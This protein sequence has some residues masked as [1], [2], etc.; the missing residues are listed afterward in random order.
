MFASLHEV[1]L[2]AKLTQYNIIE[3][4]KRAKKPSPAARNIIDI[5]TA[6]DIETTTILTG[7][8][9]DGNPIRN[10][11]IWSGQFYDGENYLQVHCRSA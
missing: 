4:R 11:I 9:S 7:I 3:K 8:D 10:G 1:D 6:F 2:F 5:V